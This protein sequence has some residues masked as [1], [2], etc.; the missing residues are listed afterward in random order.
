LVARPTGE[1]NV[2]DAHQVARKLKAHW[3]SG[4]F[5]ATSEFATCARTYALCAT[6]ALGPIATG[7]ILTAGRRFR[8]IADVAGPAACP[9]RSRLTHGNRRTAPSKRACTGPGSARLLNR[10]GR[11]LSSRLPRRSHPDCRAIPDASGHKRGRRIYL[12]G[13][14]APRRYF[15]QRASGRRRPCPIRGYTG[16]VVREHSRSRRGMAKGRLAEFRS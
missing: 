12:C 16:P 14:C 10:L 3:L 8:G 6:V 2:D 1:S 11:R 9:A 7:A 4:R 13:R 15:S 5:R